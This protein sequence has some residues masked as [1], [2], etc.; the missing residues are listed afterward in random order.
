MRIKRRYEQTPTPENNHH[1]LCVVSVGSHE[2]AGRSADKASAS[3]KAVVLADKFC[4]KAFGIELD[5]TQ[6]EVTA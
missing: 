4:Q 2:F 5:F 6:M 1:Y 3:R